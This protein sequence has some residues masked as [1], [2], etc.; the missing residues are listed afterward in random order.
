[1]SRV[2]AAQVCLLISSVSTIIALRYPAF[3]VPA[4]IFL[5]AWSLLRFW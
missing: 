3:W 5:G 4:W 2:Q 1:M